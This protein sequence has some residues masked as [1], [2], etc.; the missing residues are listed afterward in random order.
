[1]PASS[2]CPDQLEHSNYQ[3]A[4][5]EGTRQA[6]ARLVTNLLVK[7][8][9]NTRSCQQVHALQF[10]FDHMVC[11]YNLRSA[12]LGVAGSCDDMLAIPPIG[13]Q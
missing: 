12:V 5:E 10:V 4:R 9:R 2:Q 8:L 3:S 11:N 1:M 6:V 7:R 13:V